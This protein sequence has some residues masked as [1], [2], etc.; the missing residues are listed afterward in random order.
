MQ[1]AKRGGTAGA[2]RS[3]PQW[4]WERHFSMKDK[5]EQ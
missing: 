5:L 4:G 1:I 2:S 3:R